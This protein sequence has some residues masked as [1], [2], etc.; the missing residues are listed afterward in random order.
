M[1]IAAASEVDGIRLWPMSLRAT[2]ATLA[3]CWAVLTEDE[4]A[5][6]QRFRFPRD[7]RRFV[8][9]RGTV[10]RRLGTLLEVPP[11]AIRFRYGP[12]GKPTL[13]GNLRGVLHFN[14]SHSRELALLV[15]SRE[16][17]LGV[18]LEAVRPLPDLVPIALRVFSHSEQ[19]VVL[20][21][22]GGDR[23]QAFY[24][25]WTLKEAWLKGVGK[26]LSNDLARV[27]V[28]VN[29]GR[30]F[31]ACRREARGTRRLPWRLWSWEPVAGFMA[32]LAVEEADCGY[33]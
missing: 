12:Q 10:R 5:R 2:E 7:H 30:E 29:G 14:L 13:G 3:A 25:Q 4:R 23:L 17:E 16:R 9:C 11:S 32:A 24:R 18:D 6:A 26:G 21:Y 8:T 15:V 1:R 20:G 31:R 33:Q 27:E 19:R 22:D 28:L